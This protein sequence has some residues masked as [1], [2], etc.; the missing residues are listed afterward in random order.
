MDMVNESTSYV[1]DDKLYLGM[2][3]DIYMLAYGYGRWEYELCEWWQTLPGYEYRYMLAYGY[4]RWE[5]ELC[6][7]WQT[8]PGYEY[9]YIYVSICIW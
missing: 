4:G 9:R 8:I 5:Y 7:W 3:I 1:S 2:N 6:E